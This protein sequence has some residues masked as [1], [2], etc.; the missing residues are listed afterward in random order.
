MA[1][2]GTA[3]LAGLLAAVIAATYAHP[4][5]ACKC[6][7]DAPAIS[8]PRSPQ[9]TVAVTHDEATLT[10][11]RARRN[12]PVACKWHARHV[13]E[14]TGDAAAIPLTIEFPLGATIQLAIDGVVV[15]RAETHDHRGLYARRDPPPPR[16]IAATWHASANDRAELVVTADLHIDPWHACCS[17]DTNNRRHPL[18]SP[19][20]SKGHRFTYAGT[21]LQRAD[22]TWRFTLDIP[23]GWDRYGVVEGRRRRFVEHDEPNRPEIGTQVYFDRPLRLDPG[24]LVAAAGV[25]FQPGGVAPRLRVGYELA[26]P[27]LLVHTIAVET[28]TRRRVVVVP[29]WELAHSSLFTWN[30]DV[31][32][33]LGVPVQV[34]PTT[35]PGVR[36][37]GRIGWRFVHIIGVYDAYPAFRGAPIEHNGALMLQ[38]GL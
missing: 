28:D 8:G 4:A 6:A 24:G 3:A 15:A 23:R 37:L 16:T 21:P 35:R 38:L 9:T 10:C 7:I 33:G 11:D 17:P 29:A 31:G 13:L 5:A 32:L 22:T 34:L 36:V 1:R 27:D 19:W 26:W 20:N 14:H 12:Y 25:G 2:D 30:T 18:L